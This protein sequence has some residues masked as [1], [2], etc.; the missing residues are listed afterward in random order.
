MANLTRYNLE[1]FNRTKTMDNFHQMVASDEGAWVK[2]DDIKELLNSS[3]NSAMLSCQSCKRNIGGCV[4]PTCH[5]CSRFTGKRTDWH[6]Q[7]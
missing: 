1:W 3:H 2:F 5:A 4:S 7:Q 6:E